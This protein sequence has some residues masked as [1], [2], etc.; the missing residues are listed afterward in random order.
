MCPLQDRAEPDSESDVNFDDS[1]AEE[2]IGWNDSTELDFYIKNKNV[3]SKIIKKANELVPLISIFNR[4]DV[5]WIEPANPTGWRKAHCPFYDHF[6]SSPSFGF[7]V[8]RNIFN[9]FGCG[10]S[11]C[12][13]QFVSF[14]DKRPFIEVAKEIL[15]KF[16]SSDEVV[17]DLEDSQTDKSDEIILN[18]SREIREFLYTNVGNTKALEYA[19][20]LTWILDV[21]LE[22]RTLTGTVS[23][24]A[25]QGRID[26]LR[27]YLK[28]FGK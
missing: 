4:Y 9:C 19:E 2:S 24:E 14:M 25:L 18:F 10:K 27:E 8:T 12:T 1:D 16:K 20:S 13:V 22:K 26:K 15:C 28:V 21:Y 23:F 3:T 17:A 11:G 6:D 7:S 5:K